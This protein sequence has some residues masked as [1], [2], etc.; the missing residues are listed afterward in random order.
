MKRVI[1]GAAIGVSV[2]WLLALAGPAAALTNDECVTCH[3]SL[4]PGIVSQWEH[5]KMGDG[6][7]GDATCVD[8]H[9]TDHDAIM[10]AKGHVAASVCARC[11]PGQYDSFTVKDG[12]GALVNKHAIAWTRMTGGARYQIMPATE[13]LAM[14]ERC[15]NVGFVSADGSVGKCDSCHTRHTF[16]AGRSGRA[17]SVRHLPHGPGPRA[18]RHVG[19]EQARRRLHDREVPSGRRPK[20]GADLRHLPYARGDAGRRRRHRQA[21]HAQRLEQHHL[22][23]RLAGR[24]HSD[25]PLRRRRPPSP[26]PCGR[27]AAPSSRAGARR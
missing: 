14:C 11:H 9:G 20:P 3:G 1:A 19:E 8:C 27:S 10:A 15:H 5:G 17:R 16:S 12:H 2:L 23:D 6:M 7:G 26:C 25:R 21:A 24:S 4:D 13:R 18:D 22:R